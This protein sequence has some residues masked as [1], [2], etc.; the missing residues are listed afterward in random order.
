MPQI[1]NG[2]S[3]PW[4]SGEIVTAADLNGMI[5]SATITPSIITDQTDNG[6]GNVQS[7]DKLLLYDNSTG[8][9]NKVQAS[10]VLQSGI[11]I[12]TNDIQSFDRV[13]SMLID[14]WNGNL[15]INSSK[16]IT[17]QGQESGSSLVPSIYINSEASANGDIKIRSAYKNIEITADTGNVNITGTNINL[18]GSIAGS[19]TFSG[20]ANFTGTL[21]VNGATGY[22]LTDVVEYTM[23]PY[24]A[25]YGANWA[26][27]TS[28]SFT[29]P[30]GEIWVFEVSMQHQ[31]LRGVGGYEF[32]GR[33]GSVTQG[34]GPYLFFEC[35]FDSA[36]G[37]TAYGNYY[38]YSWIVNSATTLTSETFKIDAW[39]G[40]AS[41]SLFQVN[42]TGVGYN[43]VQ[44][45]VASKFR[46]YKY[47][48]A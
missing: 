26:V 22:V 24:S 3:P 6:I 31:G 42:L 12:L 11:N 36:G 35:Y 46:I 27:Y 48:T 23:S 9:L 21:Q 41:L 20:T 45:L 32:A 5:D 38:Q 40:G 7:D 19:Q 44:T 18:N 43:I 8:Q 37:S 34:T 47:K 10:E 4:V 33:Y 2:K 25:S 13:S 14:S 17:I 39:N 15:T 16:S 1:N 28:P 30:A 29:K